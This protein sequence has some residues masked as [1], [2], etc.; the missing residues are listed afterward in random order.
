VLEDE[1]AKDEILKIGVGILFMASL[2][3]LVDGMQIIGLGVLRGVQ[4]TRMPMVYAAL[5]YWGI[6]V[7]M[8]YVLGFTL[9]FEGIGVWGGLGIGLGMAAI[10]LNMRFWRTILPGLQKQAAA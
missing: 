7:P 10:F 3:Q 9:G 2:F 5:S 1:P 6:G 8:S 4:D